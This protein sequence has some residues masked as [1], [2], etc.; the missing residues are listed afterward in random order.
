M[1]NAALRDEEVCRDGGIDGWRNVLLA[2]WLFE[3]DSDAPPTDSLS[4]HEP[5]S[6]PCVC[7]CVCVMYLI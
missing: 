3:G 6:T 2:L 7:E 5:P 1:I 4:H